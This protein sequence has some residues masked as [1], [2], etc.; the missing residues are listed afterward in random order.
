MLIEL[1]RAFTL[2][3]FAEMGDKSQIL[4]MTFASRFKLKN[5]IIGITLGILLNH[6]LAIL[7]GVFIPDL[8]NI[9]YLSFIAG[10]VF[11]VFGLFSLHVTE[12]VHDVKKSKLGVTLTIAIAIFIG[13]L[14][15][16]TQLSAIVLA[17][18]TSHPLLILLGTVSAMVL[19][20]LLGIYI[21]IKFGSKIPDFILKV[22]SSFV[23]LC[24]GVIKIATNLPDTFN[25]TLYLILSSL[26][27]TVI[28]VVLFLRFRN[29]YS[30]SQSLYKQRAEE[31]KNYYSYIKDK[32]E[33]IC[34]GLDVC[35]TCSG[36]FC[37]LGYT[38]MIVRNTLH[39]KPVKYVD[40]TEKVKKDY[41]RNKIIEAL[42]YTLNVLKDNWDNSEFHALHEIRNNFELL[43]IDETIDA[44]SYQEYKQQMNI[45]KISIQ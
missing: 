30:T 16:K 39:H 40:I 20:S 44:N 18:E 13:E 9:E 24:F 1:L 31:L 41:D 8:F 22:V 21:G 2:I 45:K 12:E 25:N 28:Y 29:N 23:F 32:L 33:D 37:L 36:N 17:S 4:A 35:T 27:L 10:I 15:D 6:S 38:K 7:V 11:V 14:G 43:L 42:N 34:L 19:T 3:F 5:V 26:L